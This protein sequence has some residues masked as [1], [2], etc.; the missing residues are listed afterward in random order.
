MALDRDYVKDFFDV[1]KFQSNS[2]LWSGLAE[3]GIKNFVMHSMTAVGAWGGFPDAPAWWND[4]MKASPYMPWV[5]MCILC[6]QGGDEQ[7][8]QMAIEYTILLYFL[9]NSSNHLYKSMKKSKKK[10][11]K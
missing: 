1:F 11:K 2:A 6:F 5:M 9:Y 4:L 8:F 7:D 3:V 10:S